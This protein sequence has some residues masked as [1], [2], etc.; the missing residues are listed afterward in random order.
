MNLGI[1][2]T[3]LTTLIFGY[4]VVLTFV[5]Y[6]QSKPVLNWRKITV[7]FILLLIIVTDASHDG[8]YDYGHRK[9]LS[10]YIGL[11][12]VILF[13]ALAFMYAKLTGNRV[14]NMILIVVGYF[15]IRYSLFDI[16]YNIARNDV[17]WD[18]IGTTAGWWDDIRRMTGIYYWWTAFI[19]LIAS[20]SIID[21]TEDK[22]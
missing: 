19:I 13:F 2:F 7:Y 17:A 15:A 3:G 16:T 6:I 1:V 20:M 18:H 14:R 8:I 12:T 4:I 11:V 10:K 21:V 5:K 9:E 22:Q